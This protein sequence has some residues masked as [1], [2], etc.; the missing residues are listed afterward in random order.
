[1]F[2]GPFWSLKLKEKYHRS[3]H[4]NED[5]GD[6]KSR[7]EATGPK[8]GHMARPGTLAAPWGASGPCAFPRLHTFMR[9]SVSWK[10]KARHIFPEIYKGEGRGKSLI[11][12]RER[13]NHVAPRTSPWGNH[14]HSRHQR[15]LL[16]VGG[17]L[18]ITIFIILNISI[19]SISWSTS[20]PS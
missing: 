13:A 12:L 14:L 5:R 17:R 18:S 11:L 7:G 6:K 1:M 3:F 20:S 19:D 2:Q 10:K 8:I 4:R 16:G 15:L 9:I